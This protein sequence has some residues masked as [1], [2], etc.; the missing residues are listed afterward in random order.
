VSEETALR[1]I[2]AFLMLAMVVMAVT[3]IVAC[4]ASVV[5][6]VYSLL[7]GAVLP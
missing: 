5:I 6:I 4:V 7:S 3:F 1:I 2:G